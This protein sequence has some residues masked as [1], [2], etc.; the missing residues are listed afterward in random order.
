MSEPII[1]FIKP[2]VT[3]PADIVQQM[4]D[5]NNFI[6]P[7][8][9]NRDLRLVG[10]EKGISVRDITP[11]LIRQVYEADVVLID[12]N[13]Y[14]K[15]QLVPLSPYLCY[16]MGFR[17]SLGSGAILAARATRHLPPT[18]QKEHT[19]TYSLEEP[20][21]F[22]ERF[23][24]AVEEIL[25]G[26]DSP[27]D[28]PIQELLTQ[29]KYQAELRKRDEEIKNLQKAAGVQPAKITFRKVSS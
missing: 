6:A 8:I 5:I 10:D 21:A 23:A 24:R 25:S 14:V 1:V 18:L 29:R 12:V 17:H 27:P 9:K 3:D 4:N 2:P 28:N 11:A 22:S 19:L 16:F 15:S 26:R 13:E 7:A 20:G